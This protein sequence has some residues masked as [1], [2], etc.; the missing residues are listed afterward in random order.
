[1]S[2]NGGLTW[3]GYGIPGAAEP[4]R[5][6]D[7]S[8]ATTSD[9]SVFETWSR[10]G[11]YH[12]VVAR[13]SDH[14][15]HWT[16]PFDLTTTSP[17]LQVAT[18]EAAVGGDAGHAAVAFLGSTVALKSGQ[19][20]F[21]SGYDGIWNLYVSFTDDNGASWSTVQVTQDPVQLGFINDGGFGSSDQRNLLD[22][23]DASVTRDGRVVVA[24][25][26]GCPPGCTTPADSTHARASVAY[27]TGGELLFASPQPTL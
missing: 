17:G 8:I 2:R 11:D 24:Y 13:S 19:T 25:A 6:F 27:Q 7:P 1:M 9:N 22:F 18:F 5:G 21:D 16:Q 4:A 3:S 23:M 20:P 10:A 12:P 15:G 14:A 26:D